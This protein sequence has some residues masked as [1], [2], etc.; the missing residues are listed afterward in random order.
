MISDLRIALRHLGRSPLHSAMV[1]LILAI[2]IGANAAIFS[3]VH[4]ILLKPL[5]YAES[6]RVMFLMQRQRGSMDSPFSWP[7]LQDLIRDNR[8]FATV[9]AYT[10]R[11]LTVSGRGPA[12]QCRATAASAD[13]F[14]VLGLQPLLGRVYTAADDR[15][16]GPRVVVLHESFWR[17]KLGGDP[18]IVGQF[19]TINA[20]PHEII[21]V[22]PATAVSPS[23]TDF[24]LP[25]APLAD[26]DGWRNRR[27]QPGIFALARLK[28]GLTL[29]QAEA[30][31][32]ALGQRL[33]RDFPEAN[34]ETSLVVRPLLRVLTD[35]HRG[36][37]G[38]L[39]AA[40]GLLLLI[41]CANVASLQAV[42]GLARLPELSVRA[43]LGARRGS[44]AR[45]LFIES[46]L[47]SLLGGTLGVLLAV[48]SLDGIRLLMPPTPRL[49]GLA[50]DGVVLSFS[51]GLALVTSIL[52]GLWPAWRASQ[53]DLREALQAGGQKGGPAGSSQ[54]ARQLMVALQVSLTVVL[55]SGAALFTRSLR[56]IARFE[57]GFDSSNLLLVAASVPDTAG[58]YDTDEKRIAF[59]ENVRNRV[60]ALPGVR[61]V[62][63]NYSAPLRMD[64]S[65][66]FDIEG[67]PAFAPGQEPAMG[68]GIVDTHYFSTLGL[69]IL[70]GRNFDSRDRPDGPRGIIIDQRMAEAFWPG[71]DPIGKTIL[72][73]NP[74]NRTP[75]QRRA[76]VVGVVPT[77]QVD[78]FAEG[79][80][81]FQGYLAQSQTG[82]EQMNLIIRTSVEPRSLVDSVR[83]A[84]AGVDP[85]VPAYGI[86]TME[87]LI[88]QES[89]SQR[90]YAVLTLLFAGVALLLSALGLYGIVAQSVGARR[91]EIGIRMALGAVPRQIVRLVMRQG[92]APL[93]AGLALGL[94]GA[95]LGGRLIAGLLY[96]VSPFDPAAL[97][98]ASAV[99]AAVGFA[100][101]WLPARRTTRIDPSL[102]LRTE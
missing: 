68:M 96:R 86:A 99:L 58:A 8:V 37:L 48:W 53:V 102:A 93:A 75:E 82:S 40:V 100:A 45:L 63:L 41:A 38:V 35:H 52:A 49:A 20:Q 60:A 89:G 74:I 15:P 84:M 3:L 56:E 78:G 101:L 81:F 69:P 1:I 59:F 64:W 23:G 6:D 24:W 11:T 47:L 80:R 76:V 18:A 12:E 28:P 71:E 83:A 92:L 25:I 87:E 50:I 65:T 66:I 98:A 10:R 91:R 33:Q 46:L 70:K 29:E 9:G 55:L 90:L 95:L 27:N 39:T 57:Y 17:R 14:Q 44:L 42:R 30:D 73:G 32:L 22:M 13:F 62:G 36:S 67:R 51:V 21:G 85:N 31:L 34:T 19:L 26:N 43:A 77:V 88:R 4:A 97:L 54:L 72:R 7:N 79:S 2:G 94:L 61:S 16:G 5:P